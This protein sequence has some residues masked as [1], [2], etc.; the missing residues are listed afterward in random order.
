MTT[1]ATDSKA[2]LNEVRQFAAACGYEAEHCEHVT[3]LAERLFDAL[4]P[5]HGL[6]DRARLCLTCA[7]LLHDIRWV[8]GQKRHHKRSMEMIL[9]E[10]SLPFSPAERAM[11]ALTARYHRKAL[12]KPSHKVYASLSRARKTTVDVLAAIL[13]TADGLDRSHV[14]AI[15]DVQVVIEPMHIEVVCR[16]HGNVESE[17]RIARK[18]ADLME[19][20]FGRKPVFTQVPIKS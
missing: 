12:P 11:V 13:R 3:F 9:S 14:G 16:T 4:R 18:K 15:T 1:P 6:E 8:D 20:V 17:L 5:L 19:R 2:K 7:G 10:M